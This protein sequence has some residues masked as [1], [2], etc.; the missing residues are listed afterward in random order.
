MI[1]P[2]P[3]PRLD[4]LSG[5]RLFAIAL[6]MLH[7]L[8]EAALEGAA[9][10][11]TVVMQANNVMPLFFVLSG[12]VLTYSYGD[13]MARGRLRTSDFLVS[14][15]LR[16]WPIYIVA[17]A[18]RF[19]VDTS[20][21]G[22]SLPYAAGVLSQG[23]MIQGF[24]PPLVWFGN[25]PGWTV[26]VE[27]F[28]YLLFPWL[29]V[30]LSTLTIRQVLALS[31]ALWIAG[32]LVAL[33]YA[34]TLPDG[35]PPPGAP[36]VIFLDLLRFFPPFHLPSFLIGVVTARIFV[37]DLGG[38]APRGGGLLALAG[39][40][41]IAFT[42]GGG[43]EFVGQHGITLARWPFPFTHNGLLAPAWALLLLGL[44][45][46]C[47]AARWLSAPPLVRLGEASYALYIL[48]FPVFDAV[49]LWL[50]PKWDET[51]LFL[52]QL[53][54]VML[55]LSVLSFE[56]FEQPL[57]RAALRRWRAWRQRVGPEAAPAPPGA[58]P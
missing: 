7:H 16:L 3:R 22:V 15:F 11:D 20:S 12:F 32:Q 27:A 47:A 43:L 38:R 51:P 41:P 29:I 54:A 2:P 9:W 13:A 17:L 37:R 48:H 36:M 23:L 53:F 44:A 34:L 19:A 10:A 56:R 49:A 18:L 14:R 5:I 46:G 4:A 40:L 33:A 50:V 45:R 30:R 6:V 42:L 21:Q 8:G 24:T 1:E 58:A 55:P 35:W 26:C 52:I 57:R 25:A 39:F 28:F 31:A